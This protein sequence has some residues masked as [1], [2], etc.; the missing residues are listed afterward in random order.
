MQVPAARAERS[1]LT[2][3][4]KKSACVEFQPS[5]TSAC[6]THKKIICHIAK[7]Q[8]TLHGFAVDLLATC[9]R[10]DGDA[11]ELSIQ[12]MSAPSRQHAVDL[13]WT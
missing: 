3:K 9:C 11:T 10:L 13:L 12:Y 7:V 5:Q 4:R 6:T 8:T 1:L 2:I